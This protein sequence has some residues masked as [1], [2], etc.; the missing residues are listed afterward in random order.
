MYTHQRFSRLHIQNIVDSKN[1][2]CIKE[3]KKIMK[4]ILRQIICTLI[5]SIF[6]LGSISAAAVYETDPDPGQ[7]IVA[8]NGDLPPAFFRN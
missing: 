4:K 3:R 7:C 8:P 5:I 2:N 6:V 1:K